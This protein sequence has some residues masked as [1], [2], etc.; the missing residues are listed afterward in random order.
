MACP[1]CGHSPSNSTGGAYYRCRSL[2]HRLAQMKLDAESTSPEPL[3]FG[4]LG[5]RHIGLDAMVV[6]GGAV[7]FS[8]WTSAS[9]GV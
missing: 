6:K 1:F 8:S 4:K 3:Y 7:A 9:A 2:R 5:Y